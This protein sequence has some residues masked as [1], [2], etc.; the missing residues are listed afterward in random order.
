VF[1][2]IDRKKTKGRINS[3]SKKTNIDTATPATET[4]GG[5]IAASLLLSNIKIRCRKFFS[6]GLLKKYYS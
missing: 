1:H 4:W 2:P 6:R 5:E 3:T